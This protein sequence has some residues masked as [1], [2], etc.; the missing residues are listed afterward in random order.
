MNFC[1][2]L[3]LYFIYL[4]FTLIWRICR[5]WS[6]HY[7]VDVIDNMGRCMFNNYGFEKF[8]RMWHKGFN[9]WLIRY[10]YVPLGG[11]KNK[12]LSVVTVIAF[13]AFWHDHRIEIVAWAFMLVVFMVPEL[14]AKAYFRKKYLHLYPKQWFKYLCA[15]VCSVYI[16]L[17]CYCNLIAFGFG[18]GGIQMILHKIL[19]DPFGYMYMTIVLI[20]AC[21][22]MFYIR[23]IEKPSRN[24]WNSNQPDSYPYNIYKGKLIY[25]ACYWW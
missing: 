14:A 25:I 16:Q 13:V 5:M 3:H 10:L 11:A 9:H 1:A 18:L 20:S 8:W 19:D 2:L 4:K 21:I 6:L 17:I 7:G 22:L 24:D 12:L 23:E 15:L